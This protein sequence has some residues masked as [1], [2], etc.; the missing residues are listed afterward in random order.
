MLDHSS[1]RKITTLIFDVDGVFTDSKVIV[2]EN[3]DLVRTMNTRDGQA[4]KYALDAGYN[5]VIITKGFS[6]GVRKR[7][8]M[9][10]IQYIYDRLTYKEEKFEEIKSILDVNNEQI[11]YMGDDLPDLRLIRAAGC[12]ACPSD[13]VAEIIEAANYISPLKGGEG[14]VR[15]IVERI[16]KI[17]GKWPGDPT[18]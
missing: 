13:A 7:F 14:C 16:M 5:I 10:G 11:L 6:T 9:L 17:Q 2:M 3:G 18:I 15:E 4:L 12:G 8:E 1:L